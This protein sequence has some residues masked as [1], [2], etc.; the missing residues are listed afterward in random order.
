MEESEEKWRQS[1]RRFWQVERSI[2]LNPQHRRA[3]YN[4]DQGVSVS[5]VSEVI[6]LF[7]AGDVA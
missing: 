7:V 4:L 2:Y 3:N 1:G 6:M 5:S